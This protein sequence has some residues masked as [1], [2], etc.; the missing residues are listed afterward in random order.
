MKNVKPAENVISTPAPTRGATK[1][2]KNITRNIGFQ[3]PPLHEGRHITTLQTANA[4]I[5]TPAPTR[6]ATDMLHYRV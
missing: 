5:S 2:A 4:Q 1:N 3:L 6:G